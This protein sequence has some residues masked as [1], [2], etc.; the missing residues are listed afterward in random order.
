MLTAMRNAGVMPE[1]LSEDETLYRA[2]YQRIVRLCSMMLGNPDDGDE[3]AQEVFVKMIGQR[4]SGAEP[5]NW[6]AWL[7]RVAINGCHDRRRS[8]WWRWWGRDGRELLDSDLTTLRNA[9]EQAITRQQQGAVWRRFRK[10]SQRQQE[11]FVLR[12]VEGW[13]TREVA[14]T[15]NLSVQA[16]KLHLFRA[17]H[18]LR[19]A[20]RSES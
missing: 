12:H 18:N 19:E 6:G 17:T 13:S 16:V 4:N 9:E 10:L 11:V 5:A 3:V 14:E 8:G 15:L 1:N 2:H 7:T 20:M